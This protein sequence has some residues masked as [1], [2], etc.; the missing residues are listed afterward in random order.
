MH[1]APVDHPVA[2]LIRWKLKLFRFQ[3]FDPPLDNQVLEHLAHFIEDS[4]WSTKELKLLELCLTLSHM[5]VL[6]LDLYL[7]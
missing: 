1:Y 4:H 5:Q 6:L 3:N 7:L 2:C